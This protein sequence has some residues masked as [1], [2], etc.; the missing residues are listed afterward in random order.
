VP[1]GELRRRTQ[2]AEIKI[3]RAV[4]RFSLRGKIIN[5][6]VSAQVQEN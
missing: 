5:N 4:T 3:S 1:R 6:N 2:R